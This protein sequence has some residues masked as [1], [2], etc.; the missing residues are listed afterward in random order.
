M[1]EKAKRRLKGTAG[2]TLGEMMVAV[3]IMSFL[4]F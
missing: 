1:T 3:L 2:V 4:T